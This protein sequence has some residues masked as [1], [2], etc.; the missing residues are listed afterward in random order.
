MLTKSHIKRTMNLP[1]IEK[2]KDGVKFDF[3][4]LSDNFEQTDDYWDWWWENKS[5]NG[6]ITRPLTIEDDDD[7]LIP[8]V[9]KQFVD[10]ACYRNFLDNPLLNLL[11]EGV[12]PT[13]TAL[14][15]DSFRH[16]A[17]KAV[18]VGSCVLS[19]PNLI[20]AGGG[21]GSGKSTTLGDLAEKKE[22]PCGGLVGAD[23][24]KQLIPEY[25]L[26]KSVADGR[27]S[28]TVQDECMAM[29]R[30]LFPILIEHR[31]SFILDSSMSDKNETVA[32]IETARAAGYK[33]TMIAVLTDLKTAVRLAMHRAK[34]S[35]R[36]PNP[37]ALPKSNLLFKQHLMDYLPLFD[38]AKIFVNPGIDGIMYRV[39]EKKLGK[40]LVV[41]DKERL[42]S[43]LVRAV[44]A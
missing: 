13:S 41:L 33:L 15:R 39:A 22:I 11:N 28:G 6:R 42:D 10:T 35:R 24:F 3:A 19:E 8:T 16:I 34:L 17:M 14:G 18:A 32:R 30:E 26:I 29:L 40:Q 44:A 38:E 4:T 43:A 5:E 21:Y 9:T 31:R 2:L 20:F 23:M 7:I 12:I 37:T 36:F 1:I 27:A 25:Q